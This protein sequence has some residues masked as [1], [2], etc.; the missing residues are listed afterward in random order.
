M[1]AGIGVDMV[2]LVRVRRLHSQWGWRLERRLLTPAECEALPQPVL[3]RQRRLAMALAAKEAFVKALGTGLRW[4]ASFQQL[5][6][7]R[8]GHGAPSCV[9]ESALAALLAKRRITSTHLS[10]SDDADLALAFVVLEY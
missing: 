1:I 3:A 10:L 7:C 5:A 2:S 6:V 4:P 9:P 8:D